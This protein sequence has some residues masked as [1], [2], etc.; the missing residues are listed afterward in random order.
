M[1]E[2]FK[3]K[4]LKVLI[5]TMFVFSSWF[6]FAIRYS[7][8]YH[9][10]V[11]FCSILVDKQ[12]DIW[13][14]I[15]LEGRNMLE[16]RDFDKVVAMVPSGMNRTVWC[17]QQPVMDNWIKVKLI[18]SFSFFFFFFSDRSVSSRVLSLESDRLEIVL[19]LLSDRSSR[20]LS[21]VIV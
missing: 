10:P 15:K 13:E 1:V 21:N 19:S 6:H 18:H 2:P 11:E 9:K 20:F 5:T 16:M 12:S 17:N 4:V 7:K 3:L 8:H 14:D